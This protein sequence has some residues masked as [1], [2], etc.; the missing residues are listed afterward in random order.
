[1]IGR[2][3]AVR[4]QL[5]GVQLSPER[6]RGLAVSE[7]Q[8]ARVRPELLVWA[9]ESL[10]LSI[11]QAASKIPVSPERLEQ[12]ERGETF[13]TIPQL[14]AAARAYKRPLAVFYLPAPPRDF[15]ALRD[16]RR[17]PDTPSAPLSP[18]LTLAVRGAHE[19]RQNALELYAVLDIKA[20]EFPRM[21]T[22]GLDPEQMASEARKLLGVDLDTQFS[23][24]EKYKALGGWAS[25][26]EEAGVLVFQ[27]P[28]VEI[29]EM[30]AFSIGDRPLPVIAV[31]SK[32]A[33]R[34]R[35][36]SMM[37]EFGHILKNT[38]GLCDLREDPVQLT[39]EQRME[40]FCNAFAAALLIPTDALLAERIVADTQGTPEGWTDELLD[41]LSTKYSVSRECMLRR[42]LTL[43]LTTPEFYDRKRQ[44]FIEA[45][46]RHR[47][48]EE[49]G[50]APYHRRVI[51]RL[52]KT[53]VR[54]ALEAYHLNA[55]SAAEL[56][57]FL[58]VHLKHVSSIEYELAPMAG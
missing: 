32:D 55:I 4:V 50:F 26:L 20:P 23:W 57:D 29:D 17:L 27:A 30:R 58:G 39:P 1:M 41:A 19:L 10:G 33:P 37:H 40:A 47:E 24:R 25:A 45:Y 51:G 14:R 13:P 36:F 54:L 15:D 21:S 18:A 8:R 5:A 48:K 56:S 2:A 3:S 28:D 35:I 46:K 31:N 12:W 22:E 16:F 7:R 44:E 43:D 38:T 53:Y 49:P 9:R 42:L 34:G 6:D 52:G 11:P